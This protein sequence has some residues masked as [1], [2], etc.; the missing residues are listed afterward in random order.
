M[1][2]INRFQLYLRVRNGWLLELYMYL[3]QWFVQNQPD[4]SQRERDGS[5]SCSC[6]HV[7]PS[8]DVHIQQTSFWT[9]SPTVSS[10]SCRS[11]TSFINGQVTDLGIQDNQSSWTLS[12]KAKKKTSQASSPSILLG[13]PWVLSLFLGLHFIVSFVGPWVWFPRV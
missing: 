5:C 12:I 8:W 7:A 13:G 6:P 3:A 10:S 2:S 1:A 9:F 4:V 11:D